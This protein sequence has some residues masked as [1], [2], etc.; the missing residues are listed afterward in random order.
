[1]KKAHALFRER[2]DDVFCGKVDDADD[3]VFANDAL[4]R[5]QVAQK[6]LERFGIRVR[7]GY[8][9]VRFNQAAEEH[10]VEHGT[11]DAKDVTMRGK[12]FLVLR[13]F[14]DNEVHIGHDASRE[15]VSDSATKIPLA[16]LFVEKR[17]R[18]RHFDVDTHAQ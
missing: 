5:V 3:V 16:K 18:G 8:V 12:A 17:V 2:G 9:G 1:M 14:P 10:R 13:R 7:N 6:L 11:V 15:R 4:F